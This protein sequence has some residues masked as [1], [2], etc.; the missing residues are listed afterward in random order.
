MKWRVFHQKNPTTTSRQQQ[1]SASEITFYFSKWLITIKRPREERKKTKINKLTSKR[2]KSSTSTVKSCQAVSCVISCCVLLFGS[3][4]SSLN[5]YDKTKM[6]KKSRE[7]KKKEIRICR[8]RRLNWTGFSFVI[9]L[10]LCAFCA[11]A[12]SS[13]HHRVCVVWTQQQ[14]DK[15]TH[16]QLKTERK[17]VAVFEAWIRRTL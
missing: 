16:T 6:D 8:L 13:S 4:V 11:I 9:S 1:N 10:V 7:W 14:C 5:S 3:Q 12:W 2:R 17:I 15:Q